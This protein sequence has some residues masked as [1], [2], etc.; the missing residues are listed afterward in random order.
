MKGQ[1]TRAGACAA[2]RA[3][4]P[5]GLVLLL[6]VASGAAVGNLYY[7]QPLLDVIAQDLRVGQGT[8][9]LLVTATQVGYAVGIMFIVPLGDVHNRRRLAPTMMV[10]SA[11]SLAAC[12][13]APGIV[14][15]LLALI[16]LGLT[17][18]AGQILIPFAG[19]LADDA[20]R[21]RVVGTVLS[22][23]LTGI[24]A[25]RVVS[26]LI[27]AAL[28]WRAVF[29]IAAALMLVLG[30]VLARAIPPD[31]P[32]ATQPYGALLRSI[33]V[34]VGREPTLQI[35]LLYG[36]ISFGTFTLFWTGLT[37]LLS[38]PPYS[39]PTWAIGLFGLA[40][41][42]GALAA[43]GS[44]RLHD[45]GWSNRA[46]GLSW[47]LAI[48]AWAICDVG[49]FSVVWLLVG[50]ILLDIA[51]QSQRI[52]NQAQIFDIS[53]QARSRVNTAYITGNFVGGAVGSIVASILW[54]SGGWTAVSTIGA[55]SS[56]A[57]LVL[58]LLAAARARAVPASR[59]H[60][61]SAHQERGVPMRHASLGNL[62]VSALGLGCMGMSAYY[63]GAGTDDTESI[64]TIHRA[65]DLGVTF[66]DTAEIYGPFTNE[67][68]VARALVGRRDEVVLATKFGQLSHRDPRTA[69]A[70]SGDLETMRKLDSTPE[71]IRLAVD[72]SLKRLGTDHIDLYYQHRV[73]PRTPIEETVGALAELVA[74]G[75][76][77]YIGLSEAG[78]DTIRRA[79]AVH[80][81]TALQTE[82]S[83][84]TRD[85]E[86]EIL[87]LVRE[88]G[89]GFVAY[90]P[91]GRGFLTG[92]IRTIDQLAQDD[93]RRSNP[94]F[95]D[96]A[97]GQN[98]RIVDEVEAVAKDLGATPA[99]VA[100]AWLLA[101]G[102]DIVPIPGTKKV[103]RL[104]ENAAAANIRL[105]SE[106]LARLNSLQPAI[107]DRYPDMTPIGR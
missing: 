101:Q 14:I 34:L 9:G 6:A 68:L 58:W 32:R 40:G 52:L 61:R 10:L 16:A 25:A 99:Q 21:G 66:I 23:A 19:D 17:T 36:A 77:R 55:A 91:L 26:G 81:I 79:H 4:L 39:Y 67:E 71:N 30:G 45:G 105:T 97:F 92:Q 13:V 33:L 90:S 35:V 62:N 70:T 78:A 42:V 102:D 48:V 24:L 60:S 96:A 59:N 38:A 103:S 18:V 7:A 93:F 104:E 41:L 29:V 87:P 11:V 73:D 76:I 8:A 72:G 65:I 75:K 12:A 88:L 82:Y 80:P 54:A 107:G 89:I 20:S 53:P 28:G 5:R 2:E 100:L 3:S 27:A 37:F 56:A 47:L 22:G 57:A 49:R 63:T 46:T 94:R 1:P 31:I 106:Q 85:P 15:L 74:E 43:Q 86:A 69:G 64:R 44:G 50:I 51:T 95:A 98:L 84:W 83:L